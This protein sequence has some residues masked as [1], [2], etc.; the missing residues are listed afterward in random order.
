MWI[1]Y[2]EVLDKPSCT[3]EFSLSEGHNLT[4]S[5][6]T[7]GDA[8]MEERHLFRLSAADLK[9]RRVFQRLFMDLLMVVP[10]LRAHRCICIC[11]LTNGNLKL[12]KTGSKVEVVARQQDGSK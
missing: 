1:I 3:L 9:V 6:V 5:K 7:F 4:L 12:D 10:Y 11:L 8:I 2:L